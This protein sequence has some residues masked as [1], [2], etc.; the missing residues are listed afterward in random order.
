M[1]RRILLFTLFCG[2]I[3]LS[4]KATLA[5]DN[6]IVLS[7][8]SFGGEVAVTPPA[9]DNNDDNDNNDE[10]KPGPDIL[11]ILCLLFTIL[12]LLY[13]ILNRKGSHIELPIR[14]N[15]K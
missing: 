8:V 2:L 14:L 5:S 7:E 6:F 10:F 11:T 3:V 13:L 12:P 1:K 4:C 9:D 15:K